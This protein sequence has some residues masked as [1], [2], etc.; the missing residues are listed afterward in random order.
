MTPSSPAPLTVIPPVSRQVCV[1]GAGYVGLTAA[2]CLSHLGHR[3]R[4]LE[5][6]EHRL[7][8]LRHGR[9]PIH[10]PGL[11]E[12]VAEGMASGRLSFLDDTEQALRGAE[13]AL[14][15]VGTPPQ[16]NGE[17][18]LGHLAAAAR[19]LARAAARD[20]I[21]V[22]KST[23]PP[24]SCEAL[25]LI[26]AAEARA[27]VRIR[28]ASSP[29]FL[30]ESQAV[31]D[32]LAP[33]RVV[34][35]AEEREV[36]EVV[37]SLYPPGSQVVHCDRRGAELVKYAANT[38]LAVKISFANEV[39][40]LCEALGTDAATVLEGVGLDSRI[41][42]AFLRPGPGYGGSCLPKDVAGFRA[43]GAAL[44][45]PTPVA[46]AAERQNVLARESVTDKLRLSLGRL[47][48]ARIA[49]LGL[50][51]KPGTDDT[52]DSPGV[53]IA[54]WLVAAGAQLRCHDPLTGPMAGLGHWEPTPEA[55]VTGAD[56]TVITIGCEEF[57]HLDLTALAERMAGHVLIDAAGV[58]DLD[59]AAAAGLSVYG[60]GRGTALDFH[61][62]VW[63]PLQWAHPVA[64]PTC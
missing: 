35:G 27:G 13:V 28:V 47:A 30:R 56:A 44:D 43:V 26:V 36:A 12:L 11:D 10:E 53:A 15:C 55:A 41:G 40:R 39:A 62:I 31:A 23:V 60:V 4:C 6:D 8:Q 54:R 38:M 48:G 5:A 51:F 14:L 34:V 42:A 32:F 24:G 64:V 57:R 2:A 49:V 9:V 61:P 7:N 17:P 46:D 20:L 59:A 37:V 25:E 63:A 45:V 29:E 19:Q 50:A 18:D 16:P 58:I 21:I 1:V 52:R 3:V 33:D 22:V